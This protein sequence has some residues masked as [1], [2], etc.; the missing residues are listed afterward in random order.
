ME[1]K[2]QG[3]KVAVIGSRSITDIDIKQYLPCNCTEIISGGAKGVDSIAAK[4]AKDK[5][6]KLTEILPKYEKYGKAARIIRNKQIVDAADK[7]IA[8]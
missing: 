1:I 7:I 6:I 2:D 3:I 4:A 5:G 8:I